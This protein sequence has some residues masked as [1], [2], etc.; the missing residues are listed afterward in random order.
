MMLIGGALIILA[1][2]VFAGRQGAD[3][4]LQPLS[5]PSISGVA[6]RPAESPR[7]G[8]EWREPSSSPSRD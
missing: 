5:S 8:T 4:L 3:V 1:V 7:S 6:V 2:G